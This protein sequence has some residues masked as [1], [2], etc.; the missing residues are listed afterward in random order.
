MNEESL[1]SGQGQGVPLSCLKEAAQL[2]TGQKGQSVLRG[3]RSAFTFHC[4]CD[5][6]GVI[7][8]VLDQAL[9][10][11]ICRQLSTTSNYH[12]SENMETLVLVYFYLVVSEKKRGGGGGRRHS[13]Y[14]LKA[15]FVLFV[16][17]F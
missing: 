16:C 9:P 5:G 7:Q 17:L 11:C 14:D 12:S 4:F 8:C 3:P 6:S 13:L 10:T 2:S 15:R 1:M